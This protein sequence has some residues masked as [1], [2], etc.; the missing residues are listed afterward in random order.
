MKLDIHKLSENSETLSLKGLCETI[1]NRSGSVTKKGATEGGP[2]NHSR[3]VDWN[4]EI[5]DLNMIVKLDEVSRK[6]LL[7]ELI[8]K[9][10]RD[11]LGKFVNLHEVYADP[12]ILIFAYV[13]V[14]NA[15]G[16]NTKGGESTTLN[17]MNLE[18]VLNL[19]KELKNGSWRA[20]TA[21]RVM[22]S[23]LGTDDRRPLT[24]LS[25]YDKIV[26]SAIKIV[27]NAILRSRKVLINCLRK[28]LPYF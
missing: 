28:V 22:I 8:A 11:Q 1:Q 20:G 10:W 24:V 25:L 9:Q 27:L 13:D 5:L 16:A 26:A 15:K 21:R 6:N 18:R 4:G 17:D 12:R 2:L 19:S 7:V 23:K 3:S 14:I